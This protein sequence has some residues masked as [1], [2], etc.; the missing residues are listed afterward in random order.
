[1]LVEGKLNPNKVQI[2]IDDIEIRIMQ[3][4]CFYSPNILTA[5]PSPLLGCCHTQP[6]KSVLALKKS[7]LGKIC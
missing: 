3:C 5:P 2:F 7:V 6:K 1:M 4:L